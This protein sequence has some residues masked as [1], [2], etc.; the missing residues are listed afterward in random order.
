MK[1]KKLIY[2]HYIPLTAKIYN[3]FFMEATIKAGIQVEYW[4]L[5]RLFFKNY[6]QEDSAFLLGDHAIHFDH[7]QAVEERIKQQNISSTLFISIVS[8]NYRVV[9]L[10]RLFTQYNCILGVFGRDMVPIGN[11]KICSKLF[12][13]TPGKL[14]R[15]WKNKRAVSLKN[16]GIVKSYDIVFQGGKQGYKSLGLTSSKEIARAC[17]VKINSSDYD[18][19]QTMVRA[20]TTKPQDYIVFLDSYLPLH[21]DFKILGIKLC[22][23][24]E[25]YRRLNAFFDRLET[26]YKVPVIIAA[27][28]KALKYK[29]EDYFHGRRVEF[30]K[31]EELVQNAMLVV[32]HY[33]TAVGY[34]VLF[35]KNIQLLSSSLFKNSYVHQHVLA[36]ARH[37]GCKWQ[38]MEDE[39]PIETNAVSESRYACY[40]YDFLCF[41]ET[42]D[43]CS[44]SIFLNFLLND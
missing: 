40:K 43:L 11:L 7:Y 34:A 37:L 6:G 14:L 30:G 9:K 2:F 15:F 44:E 36:F 8:Y 18:K 23:P 4:D 1:F 5:S 33:S 28:P 3:D 17:V 39:S 16:S 13:L 35:R 31:T 20:L 41:P 32:A 10:F 26:Q 21:P 25:Y 42:E 22:P 38:Y 27:H 19:Y 24:E 29:D 12:R